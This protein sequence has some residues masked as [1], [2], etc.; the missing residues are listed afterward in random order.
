ME[1]IIAKTQENINRCVKIR[2]TVFVE[3]Q[4]VPI[5]LEMD[6]Y[7]FE[8]APCTHFL[9]IENGEDLGTCRIICEHKG[10]AHLQRFCI[11]KRFRGQKF[12]REMLKEIDRFC[13]ENG[14]KKIVLNSQCYAI[15]FY[16]KSGYKVVSDEFDD[17]GIPHKAMEK[18]IFSAEFE[19]KKALFLSQK[20]TLDLFLKNGAITQAQYN[21]SFGD[22]VEKM[23]M[24]N[25]L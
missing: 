1:I 8:G 2:K 12:G 17:A 18:E 16:E 10:E 13:G 25:A 5:S 3:E 24:K 9:F 21:K 20:N 15:P 23:G 4:N 14:Y 6:E 22:L 7:D 19:K 11:H